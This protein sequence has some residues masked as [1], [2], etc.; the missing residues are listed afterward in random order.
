M[1]QGAAVSVVDRDAFWRGP[2]PYLG[3]YLEGH[4]PSGLQSMRK[5]SCHAGEDRGDGEFTVTVSVSRTSSIDASARYEEATRAAFSI[6]R[7]KIFLGTWSQ[8]EEYRVSLPLTTQRRPSQA[9]I[10]RRIL[11]GLH[12]LYEAG[13]DE[14]DIEVD[15]FGIASEL[16]VH[17]RLVSRAVE[18]LFQTGLIEDPGTL[19]RNWQSGQF[20]V[21]ARGVTFV[22]SDAVPLE[23]YLQDVYLSTAR[24]VGGLDPELGDVFDELRDAA[25]RASGSANEASGF[26]ARVRDFVERLTD[27]LCEAHSVEGPFE[28]SKTINKVRALTQQVASRTR[29]N[30]VRA[31]AE[32][33]E[34]HWTRLN[35]VHQQGVHAGSV[36]VQRLLAYTV[37][38]VSDL[39]DLLAVSERTL[40]GPERDSSLR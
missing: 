9:T 30:Y 12:A 14:D 11:Y 3:W 32:V 19:G 1:H 17:A 20:W 2:E 21:S 25:D 8:A 23:A 28:R 27:R 22:E 18:H 40:P 4:I 36:E 7:A 29:Q 31:L 39:L 38:F 26:A 5:Y 37:L 13:F 35:D 10:R 15:M 6:C 33:V 16:G 34:A 24:H